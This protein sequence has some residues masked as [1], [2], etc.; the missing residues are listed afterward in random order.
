MVCKS[1]LTKIFKE[2]TM[3]DKFKEAAQ[4]L[5][6]DERTIALKERLDYVDATESGIIKQILGREGKPL[7]NKQKFIYQTKIEPTLVE[8]CGIQGC[9]K[10]VPAGTGYCD[11]CQIEYV[12]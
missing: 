10:F 8:K 4:N 3:S 12:E 9:E 11:S 6:D 2:V 5:C 7:S 1:S